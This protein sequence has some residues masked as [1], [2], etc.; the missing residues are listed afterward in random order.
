MAKVAI[1]GFGRI[2]R[3]F[4]KLVL[5]QASSSAEAL[6]DRQDKLDIVAINDLGDLDNL[7]YLLKYDS[8]YGRFNKEISA[9]GGNLV[10]D[11][12]SYKFLQE[13]DMAKLPWKDLG[14]DIVVESSGAFETYDK[15]SDHKIA[16]AKRVVLTAPA[17]DEDGSI[18]SPQVPNDGKTVLMGVN[19]DDL[20]ICS[21]SS[22]G[23]CTTN[24]ASPILQ[25]LSENIGVKKAFLNT[26]HGYTA[27]Q[28]LI[29]SPVRGHD[30]RR[31]RAAGVN[32]VPSYTGAALA[33]GR[34]VK[35]VENK[36]EG[37]AMRVPVVT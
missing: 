32:I 25:I 12:K 18:S 13:K 8:A 23:S 3:A 37:T 7:A 10:V 33:V 11:G 34:V 22:N 27:T 30:F 9:Q 19:E 31:G 15:I 24:S 6:A 4:F 35:S 2:G 1:N 14:V 16:G 36:F 5:Q 26:V 21:I 28:N 29:D 20:K 17:K